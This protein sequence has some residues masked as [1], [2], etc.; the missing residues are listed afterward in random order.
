[1][2]D[3]LALLAE[4]FAQGA[5]DLGQHRSIHRFEERLVL[6]ELAYRVLE[7]EADA[8]DD[9][10]A[11][12]DRGLEVALDCVAL[13]LEFSDLE[14]L[15]D[16]VPQALALGAEILLED[17]GGEFGVERLVAGDLG[18]F[19]PDLPNCLFLWRRLKS[20]STS[21]IFRLVLSSCSSPSFTMPA[22]SG[23]VPF[24]TRETSSEK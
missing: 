23:S 18:V 1:M 20:L 8:D 2:D 11:F 16:V 24:L 19:L 3:V 5:L 14:V 22:D 7:L 9:S 21:N 13:A 10:R 17:L 4:H 6:L 12:E 15:D